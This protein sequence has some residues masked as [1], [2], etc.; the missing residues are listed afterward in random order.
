MRSQVIKSESN[1]R[2]YHQT[3]EC[4]PF[5]KWA[6]GKTQLLS[7]IRTYLP[8]E[9]ER[10]FEP[11]LGGGAMFFYLVSNRNLGFTSFLSDTNSELINA[12]SIVRDDVEE[13]IKILKYHQRQYRK[14]PSQ[15]Y[16]QLRAMTKAMKNVE[17]AARFIALNKTCYNGLYRVNKNGLFNVPMGRY[18]NPLICD[19]DNLRN[20]SLVLRQSDS[21]IDVSDYW[22]ILIDNADENDFIY[23]DPPYNP[24]SSTAN[25]TGYTDTGFKDDDQKQLAK[26]F[27]KLDARG[28]YII[29]SNSDTP[30]VRTLYQDYTD[31]TMEIDANRA[32]NSKAS[33]RTGHRELLIRNYE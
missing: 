5:V 18:K 4:Y 8:R 28:C 23:L 30:L 24:V 15:Y 10:Y 17:T 22:K 7:Q 1:C 11:F 19:T 26:I 2:F 9:F 14:S 6:G 12:Y 29:L 27:R 32:I 31:Y 33:L 16:Y 21:H 25:F 3:T 13:L 20:V